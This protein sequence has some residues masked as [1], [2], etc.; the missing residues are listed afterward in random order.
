MNEPISIFNAYGKIRDLSGK[1][2]VAAIEALPDAMRKPLFACIAACMALDAGENRVIEARK[3]TRIKEA[4]YDQTVMAYEQPSR[5][6]GDADRAANARHVATAQAAMTATARRIAEIKAVSAAQHAGYIPPKPFKNKLKAA[7]DAAS[8]ALTE[9]RTEL[10]RATTELRKLEIKAGEAINAWRGC[11]P[12]MTR[13]TLMRDHIAKGNA[14]RLARVLRGE[15]ADAP[16]IVPQYQS[17]LDRIKGAG[18]IKPPR[19]LMTA[20]R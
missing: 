16:K 13:D 10:Q 3:T 17:E 7:M 19:P 14:D 8:A 5:T 9:A 6:E 4:A 2:D 20:R 18:K 12:V 15:P 1:A 11:L